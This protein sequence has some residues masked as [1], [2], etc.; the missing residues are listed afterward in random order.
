MFWELRRQHLSRENA[1]IWA[2]CVAI[3]WLTGRDDPPIRECSGLPSRDTEGTQ[4]VIS[5]RAAIAISLLASNL[6]TFLGTQALA[7]PA[8]DACRKEICNSAVAT[9]MRT[10]QSLN[11]YARTEAEKNAYCA[12]FFPGCMTQTI[13]PDLPW[14]SPEMVARF[15]KCPS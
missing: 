8:G 10:D 14:Y 7:T 13:T 11:P 9:C 2:S 3:R 5:L 12:Q 15:L 6:P 1:S 4:L